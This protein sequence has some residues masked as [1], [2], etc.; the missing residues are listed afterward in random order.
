MVIA[1]QVPERR[2]AGTAAAERD[3]F[4]GGQRDA[5]LQGQR[6]SD[7]HRGAQPAGA[8][9]AL[10]CPAISVPW[11]THVWP[12]YELFPFS[13]SVPVP[14]LVRVWAVAGVKSKSAREAASR[15]PPANDGIS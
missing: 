7:G 5:T 2:R 14:V 4:A 8:P 3:R 12:R 6:R 10:L 13:V 9:S 1:A 11:L 15:C